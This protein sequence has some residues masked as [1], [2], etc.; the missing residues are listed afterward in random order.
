MLEAQ[1]E[2]N[3]AG[4]MRGISSAIT[5]Y[6]TTIG[7]PPTGTYKVTSLDKLKNADQVAV[8]VQTYGD[9]RTGGNITGWLSQEGS[10]QTISYTFENGK[11]GAIFKDIVIKQGGSG[12][13]M[14][15]VSANISQ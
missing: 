5:L 11:A 15:T 10:R 6:F 8:Y 9:P 7:P 1:S 2:D 3:P 4:G 12:A 13:T 14:G